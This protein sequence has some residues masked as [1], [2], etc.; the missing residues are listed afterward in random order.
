MLPHFMM[1]EG[2][3]GQNV[4]LSNS[5]DKSDLRSQ[6]PFPRLLRTSWDCAKVAPFRDGLSAPFATSPTTP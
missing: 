5:L 6:D 2:T 4:D 1:G 3:T